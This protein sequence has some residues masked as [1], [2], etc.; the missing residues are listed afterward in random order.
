MASELPDRICIWDVDND[1][2][3]SAR[4]WTVSFPEN[5]PNVYVRATTL[6][7]PAPTDNQRAIDAITSCVGLLNALGGGDDA[8]ITTAVGELEYVRSL[9]TRLAPAATDTGLETVAWRFRDLWEGGHKYWKFTERRYDLEET[10]FR[11]LCDRSQAEELL[12]VERAK[13]RDAMEKLVESQRETLVWQQRAI[14]LKA[15]NA[16][17]AARIK[18]LEADLKTFQDGTAD[19][20]N[21]KIDA[22]FKAVDL[23]AKLATAQKALEPFAKIPVST[24]PEGRL[25]HVPDKHPYMVD[26]DGNVLFTASDIRKARAVLGGKP[27]C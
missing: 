11:A 13:Y 3:N 27:S 23:E 20:V 26:L 9:F 12:A 16:A 24:V 25:G 21:E 2:P 15:D 5:H 17:Q 10:E 22:E 19:L 14:D 8:I 18:E 4:G 1:D 7:R 6:T